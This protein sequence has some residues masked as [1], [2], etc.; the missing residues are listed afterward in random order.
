[1]TPP[2]YDVA[3]VGA[4]ILG[5]A[6]AYHLARAGKRVVVCERH[7]RAVGASVRNFGMVWP[8]GQPPGEMREIALR[9]REI[10]LEMLEASGIWHRRTG[11]LHLAYHEDEAAVLQ[12]FVDLAPANGYEC[13][14]LAP[15]QA[16]DRSPV[17]R[18]EGLLAAMGSASELCVNPRRVLA[19]LPDYL[20]KLG[21]EFRF[22]AAAT[23][24][25]EGLLVAGGQEI[26]ADNILLCT[27]DDFESLFP[28]RFAASGLARIKLQMLKAR[29]KRPG[30]EIGPHLCAGLTLGH[31]GNF[32]VCERLAP[33]MERFARELPEH[34]RWGVHL[35]VSQHEDGSLT[36]GDSH[37]TV[38]VAD[39]FLRESIDRLILDY[40]DTFLPLEGLEIVERWHGVYAKHPKQGY[41]IDRPLPGVMIVTGVGGAGMTLSFGL[42]ERVVGLLSSH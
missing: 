32:R 16:L 37:E 2:R 3:I 19:A 12:E 26:R 4:G 13:E 18:S 14:M 30:T 40:L 33:A 11:S 15:A 23:D 35:L 25:E 20:R 34:V 42:A 28:E 22:G 7:P 17:I 24:V 38:D 9:S 31:Y 21:V 36:V 5:L 41:L 27:G 39:P 29:F 10:W 6:H 1:M 8:I